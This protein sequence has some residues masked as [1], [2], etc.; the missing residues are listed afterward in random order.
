MAYGRKGRQLQRFD[1]YPQANP[2]K[3]GFQPAQILVHKKALK[4]HR[5]G[6]RK[7]ADAVAFV[8]FKAVNGMSEMY[9]ELGASKTWQEMS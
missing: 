7:L 1:I 3:I 9:L 5:I 8:N 4:I 2:L 6:Q